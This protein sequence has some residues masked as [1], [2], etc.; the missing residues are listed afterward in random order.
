[1]GLFVDKDF[2]KRGTHCK[3]QEGLFFF[4][5]ITF[6]LNSSAH[7]K[8]SPVEHSQASI[9]EYQVYIDTVVCHFE[10]PSG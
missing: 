5:A 1:M 3:L 4:Y 6:N 7:C 9:S 10:S 2:L 8:A